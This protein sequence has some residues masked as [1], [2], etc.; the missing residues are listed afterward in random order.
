MV[1]VLFFMT[2][3]EQA[4]EWLQEYFQ[5]NKIYFPLEKIKKDYSYWKNEVCEWELDI[6]SKECK[7]VVSYDEKYK[8]K[9]Y[10][11]IIPNTKEELF[12]VLN[13]LEK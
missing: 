1:E 9:F 2:T 11:F 13:I 8:N 7:I 12:T 10:N 6:Y 3:L 4:T 5:I